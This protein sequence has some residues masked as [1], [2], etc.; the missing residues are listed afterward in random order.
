MNEKNGERP[1]STDRHT[2]SNVR[3]KYANKLERIMDRRDWTS[4]CGAHTLD[5]EEGHMECGEG[6]MGG[7]TMA[8]E[9]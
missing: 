6:R 1:W 9:A 4:E 8:S 2:Q 5:F 7:E 3:G